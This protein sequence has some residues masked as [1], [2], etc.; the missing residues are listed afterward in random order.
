MDVLMFNPS[1]DFGYNPSK[2]SYVF[3]SGDKREFN[4]IKSN[5]YVDFIVENASNKIS[6]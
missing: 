2:N 6:I 3:F 5:K 1:V 4:R